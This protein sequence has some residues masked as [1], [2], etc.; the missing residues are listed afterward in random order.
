[1]SHT[2]LGE[3]RKEQKI[4]PP[5]LREDV[6][7]P[8]NLGTGETINKKCGQTYSTQDQKHEQCFKNTVYGSHGSDFVRSPP[9]RETMNQG[10]P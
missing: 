3:Q 4:I 2:L 8:E 5:A 10:S 9:Q 6:K 1:M 7:V